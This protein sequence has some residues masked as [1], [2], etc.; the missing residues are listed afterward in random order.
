MQKD[1]CVQI[2]STANCCSKKGFSSKSLLFKGDFCPRLGGQAAGEYCGNF[3]FGGAPSRSSSRARAHAVGRPTPLTFAPRLFAHFSKRR[4][5]NV[6]SPVKALSLL[7]SGVA[8]LR[9]FN[10]QKNGPKL[11]HKLREAQGCELQWFPGYR[12][13]G[14]LWHWPGLMA[15]A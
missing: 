3:E 10:S 8:T 9:L 13:K 15:V 6:P 4:T 1:T 11:A 5:F 14:V 7:Q 12:L 2:S